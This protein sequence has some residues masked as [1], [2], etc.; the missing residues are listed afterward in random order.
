MRPELNI[1]RAVLSGWCILDHRR[2]GL[3]AKLIDR[4]VSRTRELGILTLHVN[5]WQNSLMAKQLLTRMGFTF[6]RR[7]L[8]LRLDLSKTPLPEIGQISPRCR[9]LQPGE[10]ERLTQ[11]QNR[12][13]TGSLGIQCQ[14]GRRDNLPHPSSQ[15][16][17]GGHH[18]G[19]RFG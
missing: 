6:V 3:T 11:L 10:E 7:F 15:L 9:P 19:L 5:I 1:G 8:E 14:H 12:S 4:A 13:F 16:L 17:P 2:G 18:F